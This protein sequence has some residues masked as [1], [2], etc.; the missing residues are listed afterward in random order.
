M[1]TPK[2][3]HP[4]KKAR[5][6][7]FPELLTQEYI[8]LGKL[9]ASFLVAWS[10]ITIASSVTL[11][12]SLSLSN[13]EPISQILHIKATPT[14]PIGEQKVL[15]ILVNFE[16][17][18]TQPYTVET[19]RQMIFGNVNNFVKEN[20][21][22]KAWLTGDV[23][24][25]YTITYNQSACN[26]LEVRDKAK[27]AAANAGYVLGNYTHFMYIFPFVPCVGA[28]GSSS[29]GT[30]PSNLWIN[31][32]LNF[33]TTTHEFGHVL[34]LV[35]S[36][37]LDCG[38]VSIGDNCT[39]IDYGDSLDIMGH[40]L[41]KGHYNAYQKELLGWLNPLEI[42]QSGSYTVAPFET[43]GGQRALKIPKK[44][45]TNGQQEWYYIEYRQ[46]IGFDSYLASNANVKNGIVIHTKTADSSNTGFVSHLIDLTPETS[47]W[48][49]PA[50]TVGKTFRDPETD[51]AI[52]LT[53]ADTSGAVVSINLPSSTETITC[54]HSNPSITVNP[55]T[56]AGQAGEQ[57]NYTITITN[58]DS[59]T[60]DP[61][62]FSVSVQALTGWTQYPQTI[63]A[64][65]DPQSSI[66]RTISITSPTNSS[67]G[68]YTLTGKVKNLTQNSFESPFN[69]S[70]TVMP[71]NQAPSVTAGPDQTISLP[72]EVSLTA[73]TKDDGL[74][75]SPGALSFSWTQISGPASVTFSAPKTRE[76]RAAFSQKGTYVLRVSTTDGALTSSDD[77]A[78]TVNAQNTDLPTS[79]TFIDSFDDAS[80]LNQWVPVKNNFVI[81]QGTA[82]GDAVAGDH[83][84]IIKNMN[85]VQKISADFASTNN[86]INPRM[87]LILGYQDPSNYYLLYAQAGGTSRFYISKM[88]NGILTPLK[89]WSTSNPAKGQFFHMEASLHNGT[90]GLRIRNS[91]TL[92][93]VRDN[94]FPIG[95]AGVFISTTKTISPIVDNVT[96]VA[97]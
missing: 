19:A 96:A 18:K 9:R 66:T 43:S 7:R 76:T 63:Q 24:P 60:C 72:N 85:S 54:T 25:W 1:N 14:N 78:I 64:P 41:A 75:T 16:N 26:L 48:N 53:S 45:N 17:N 51:L 37:A 83:S 80:S 94:T 73:I 82:R 62:L 30:I 91:T 35:H 29:I 36:L 89:Y 59:T 56:Q 50:L 20:S 4:I 32:G 28:P 79:S 11:S 55:T 3:T 58:N 33:H 77:V 97:P 15:A 71:K 52:T 2:G 87:G 34:G 67:F 74:P 10:I 8:S 38:S 69:F 81:S 88:Q 61:A 23:T 46:P 31:Q 68:T 27:A 70:Y 86:N 21:D 93:T 44:I 12:L 39:S 5:A 6:A 65:M 95:S 92:L 40:P 47:S 13:F 42:T 49:D 57:I 90:L 22:Q 84:A